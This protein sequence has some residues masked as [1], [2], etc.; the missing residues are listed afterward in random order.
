MHNIN[1]VTRIWKTGCWL[2]GGRGQFYVLQRPFT[3]LHFSSEN[4][5]LWTNTCVYLRNCGSPLGVGCDNQPSAARRP[6]PD[7]LKVTL[8]L[9]VIKYY[10]MYTCDNGTTGA[11][12]LWG[13]GGTAPCTCALTNIWPHP[14]DGDLWPPTYQRYSSIWSEM[15]NTLNYIIIIS[16]LYLKTYTGTMNVKLTSTLSQVPHLR[17]CQ[18][19]SK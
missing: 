17:P 15:G 2:F 6:P 9:C 10:A 13:S 12:F 11:S 5:F 4:R 8:P 19:A 18:V 1:D 14:E 3:Q 16:R 7:F